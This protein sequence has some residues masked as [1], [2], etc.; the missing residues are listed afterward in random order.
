MESRHG[1]SC[2]LYIYMHMRAYIYKLDAVFKKNMQ[3][4]YLFKFN[5]EMRILE[6]K[7]FGLIYTE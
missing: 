7:S 5:F 3:I 4:Q 1:G 6:C 2:A